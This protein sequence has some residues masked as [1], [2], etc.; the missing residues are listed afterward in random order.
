MPKGSYR[1]DPTNLSIKPGEDQPLLD[2][3]ALV[4]DLGNPLSPNNELAIPEYGREALEEED[5]EEYDSEDD[6][7]EGGRFNKQILDEIYHMLNNINEER[8]EEGFR[9]RYS[10]MA[11]DVASLKARFPTESSSHQGI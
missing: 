6:S 3:P 9:Q 5:D 1:R 7:E 2:P 10:Q 11:E 8:F 4:D